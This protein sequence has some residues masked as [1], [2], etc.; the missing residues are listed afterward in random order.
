MGP[1]FNLKRPHFQGFRWKPCAQL[2]ARTPIESVLVR[3]SLTVLTDSAAD[4]LRAV[5]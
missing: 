2:L 4:E 5:Y 3:D 1:A